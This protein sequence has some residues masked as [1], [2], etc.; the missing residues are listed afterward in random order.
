MRKYVLGFAGGDVER[1]CRSCRRAETFA[2]RAR[3]D[4][5]APTSRQHK[6]GERQADDACARAPIERGTIRKQEGVTIGAPFDLTECASSSTVVREARVP[7][8]QALGCLPGLLLLSPE[9]DREP[10]KCCG[11]RRPRRSLRAVRARARSMA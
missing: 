11:S 8:T 3:R 7:T 6:H 5:K 4:R 10:L 2:R 1:R 9:L